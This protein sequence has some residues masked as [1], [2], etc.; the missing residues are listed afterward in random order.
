MATLRFANRTGQYGVYRTGAPDY[1]ACSG[2]AAEVGYVTFEVK[3]TDGSWAEGDLIGVLVFKDNNNYKV[4]LA[5][6]DDTNKYLKVVTEEETVGTI[7]DADAVT[8][9]GV[10]TEKQLDIALTEPQ[11]NVQTGTTYTLLTTDKGK[12]ICFNNGAAVTVTIDAALPVNFACTVVQEG[13]GLVS[14]DPQSTD[15][16]NG[17]TLNVAL[18]GQWKSGYLYQRTEG[19]WVLIK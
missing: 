7:S 4:W 8:V 13:V 5:S 3:D 17:A 10:L 2:G 6:W 14:L 11:I 12:T 9:R 15:T 19:A 1:V 18:A 16:L